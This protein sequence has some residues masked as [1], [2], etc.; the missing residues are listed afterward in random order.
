M[1]ELLDYKAK[2]VN[3]ALVQLIAQEAQ[4]FKAV[5]RVF[6]RVN[7]ISSQFTQLSSSVKLQPM[8]YDASRYINLIE[9]I[10][11]AV[12]SVRMDTV[13]VLQNRPTHL[14]ETVNVIESKVVNQLQPF[15]VNLNTNS[16]TW[17]KDQ[18]IATSVNQDLN[19]LRMNQSVPLMQE[20]NDEK[21][22]IHLT[23][24]DDRKTSHD[25]LRF[26]NMRINEG[27]QGGNIISSAVQPERRIYSNNQVNQINN[28]Q[29]T[30]STNFNAIPQNN[31]NPFNNQSIIPQNKIN[32]FAAQQTNINQTNFN[33]QQTNFNAQ[34]T[35]FNQAG[36][37]TV[38]TG[39]T[40]VDVRVTNNDESLSISDSDLSDSD[41]DDLEDSM[42]KVDLKHKDSYFLNKPNFNAQ[43]I[44][45]TN[46][47]AQQINNTNFNAQQTMNTQ[48]NFNQQSTMNTNYNEN[49]NSYTFNNPNAYVGSSK[50]LTQGLNN[51][52]IKI[53]V[54]IDENNNQNFNRTEGGNNFNG[55]HEARSNHGSSQRLN[56]AYV[57]SGS[58]NN[59]NQF[60]QQQQNN[61]LNRPN[62]AY[63][64]A[65]INNDL[66]SSKNNLNFNQTVRRQSSLSSLN[67][68]LNRSGL[69][70]QKLSSA[71]LH[72]INN[73]NNQ[74]NNFNQT[75]SSDVRRAATMN[76]SQR[77]MTNPTV[78]TLRAGNNLNNY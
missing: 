58:S 36:I 42:N 47:N 57:N 23:I 74:N 37:N 18:V 68:S 32:P 78:K 27:L 31:I 4:F 53:E 8:Q 12:P 43:Q 56:T 67:N 77:V 63:L 19:R 54:T 3:P 50:N 72:N 28:Q 44:N 11:T 25:N 24:P 14:T 35:N 66:R 40:H 7:G 64:N 45:N 51:E 60:N 2:I 39:L 59:L 6:S 73:N 49:A 16:E 9:N 5:A 29:F 26:S 17:R 71:N 34:Q 38:D 69:Y 70:D 46:F 1:V 65:P 20:N 15:P 55:F 13:N 33:A 22:K 10:N 48:S 41:I 62:T 76:S 30:Q 21:I 52:N 75:S 61:Q